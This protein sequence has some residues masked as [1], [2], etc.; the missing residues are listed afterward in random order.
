MYIMF[1][2]W[3]N[4]REELVARA[5][6]CWEA[7]TRG[8]ACRKEFLWG[9]GAVLYSDCGGGGKRQDI[10]CNF[11]ELQAHVNVKTGEIQIRSPV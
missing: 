11:I 8:V 4:G 7:V 2:E 6:G 5:C 3:E 10:W 1:I 9:D